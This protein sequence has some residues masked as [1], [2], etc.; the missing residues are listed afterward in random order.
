MS[1]SDHEVLDLREKEITLNYRENAEKKTRRFVLR[2]HT[3]P[4]CDKY[5]ELQLRPIDKCLELHDSLESA[6]SG[7][8]VQASIRS[9][10]EASTD[11]FVWLLQEPADGGEPVDSDWIERHLNWRY[12][13]RIVEIQDRLN[14][15]E[16]LAGKTEAWRALT[17]A[18]KAGRGSTATMSLPLATPQPR[19]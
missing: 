15:M 10:M 9:L 19:N 8:V 13:A 11:L 3:G 12:R 4:E 7:E 1:H 2:E 18:R 14:G 6:G 16:E 5:I 17:L